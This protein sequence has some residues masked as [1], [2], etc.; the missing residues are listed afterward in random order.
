VRF[1]SLVL[2]LLLVYA[3]PAAAEDTFADPIVR[4]V[5]ELDRELDSLRDISWF[6]GLLDVCSREHA[7]MGAMIGLDVN[8]RP[9]SGLHLG[10]ASS[11]EIGGDA[12]GIEGEARMA[13]GLGVG[14]GPLEVRVLGGVNA[15]SVGPAGAVGGSLQVAARVDL[16]MVIVSGA[17]LRTRALVDSDQNRFELRIDIPQIHLLFGGQLAEYSRSRDDP[18]SGGAASVFFYVGTHG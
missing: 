10:Y 18:M 5:D 2:V 16:R 4:A 17:W 1:A 11:G 13:V 6:V 12:D 14:G 3:R 8:N 15:G 7:A 9:E